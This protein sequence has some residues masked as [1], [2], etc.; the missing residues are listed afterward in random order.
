[1][2]GLVVVQEILAN[3]KEKKGFGTG[4]ESSVPKIFSFFASI[5]PGTTTG[6]RLVV[7]EKKRTSAGKGISISPSAVLLFLQPAVAR[8]PEVKKE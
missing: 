3:R 1:M 7:M 6:P 2:I 5:I 8:R 4:R